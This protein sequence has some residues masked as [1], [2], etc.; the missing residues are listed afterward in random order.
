MWDVERVLAK[1]KIGKE[2]YYLVEWVGYKDDPLEYDW[3]SRDHLWGDDDDADRE[4]LKDFEIKN[5]EVV[6][7]T[8]GMTK[9]ELKKEVSKFGKKHGLHAKVKFSNSQVVEVIIESKRGH[10]TFPVVDDKTALT[11]HSES[12]TLPYVFARAK[13]ATHFDKTVKE[14]LKSGAHLK[15]KCT[16]KVCVQDLLLK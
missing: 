15:E 16:P 11:I 10:T 9:D 1:G 8:K 4:K 7:L 12:L 13:L 6:E 3:I 5:E 14:K 2:D